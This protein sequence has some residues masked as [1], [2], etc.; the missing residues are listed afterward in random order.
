MTTCE[1]Q[2][3]ALKRRGAEYVAR[4]LSGKSKREELE[5]GG[6]SARN[7]CA[8]GRSQKNHSRDARPGRVEELG[9]SFPVWF[10]EADLRVLQKESCRPSIRNWR[11]EP[12]LRRPRLPIGHPG[13]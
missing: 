13:V 6:G 11:H 12:V 1:P 4:L 7:V 5:F 10:I 8:P 2:C 9:I 3:I